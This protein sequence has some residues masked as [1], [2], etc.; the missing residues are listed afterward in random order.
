LAKNDNK[1]LPL[2][3][4]IKVYA[5]G[6]AAEAFATYATVVD[7]PEE[8]DVILLKFGT[9]FTPVEE[10]EY[11]LQR[12][13]HEGRLDFPEQ[14]K[15]EMLALIN[16][17]P[18]I[19]ILTMKR[20]AVI[21]EISSASKGLIVDFD[22]ED[23]V[24]AELIFGEFNP[25]GKLPVEMPSSVEAVENQLEDVPHDSKNPVFPFGHGLQYE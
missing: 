15:K 2:S 24:L 18:T 1:I 4:N 22:C 17:K 23:E 5:E 10:P 19:S 9:P 21:P 25:K 6:L 20:P 8:A 16:K 13:F 11:F 3:K 7:T 14:K 12:I